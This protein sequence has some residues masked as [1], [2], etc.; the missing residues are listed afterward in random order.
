MRTEIVTEAVNP[1]TDLAGIKLYSFKNTNAY[2]SKIESLIAPAEKYLERYTGRKL[3]TQTVRIWLD[4]DEYADKLIAYKN[5]ITLSTFN[6]SVINSVTLYDSDNTASI[7][8]SSDYRLSGDTLSAVSKLVYNENTSISTYNL[9]LVDGVAIEI[10][11]GYGLTSDDIPTMLTQ[12]LSVIIDHWVSFGTKSSTETLHDVTSS[13]TALI[14]PF[15]STE[16]YF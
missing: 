7:V 9:R 6:A 8:D 1:A 4:R 15:A 13:F 11:C 16:N 3:I 10:T 5:S 14:Q 12:S 2:D